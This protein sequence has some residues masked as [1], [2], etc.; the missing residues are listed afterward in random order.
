MERRDLSRRAELVRWVVNEIV[1]NPGVK[2]T[3]AM[4]E[5]WLHVSADVAYR[6][7]QRLVEAGLLREIQRGVWV[8][9][10]DT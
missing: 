6:I 2:V 10:I 1:Q 7:V 4:I 5:Q 3:T 8:R 9:R